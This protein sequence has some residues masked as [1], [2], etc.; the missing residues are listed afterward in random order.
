MR[1][2]VI[3]KTFQTK[4]M[5]QEGNLVLGVSTIAVKERVKE[6]HEVLNKLGWPELVCMVLFGWVVK[7]ERYEEH[8]GEARNTLKIMLITLNVAEA[9]AGP[10]Q[11]Q[12][13]L[14]CQWKVGKTKHPF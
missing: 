13:A 10:Y 2:S 5:Q 6:N 12:N 14:I 1:H 4:K 7:L 3:C 11:T 8:A 9:V